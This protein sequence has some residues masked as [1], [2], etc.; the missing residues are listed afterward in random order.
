MHIALV[1]AF[2]CL[3]SSAEVEFIA[4]FR[5][6]AQRTGHR[7]YEVVTSDDIHDCKPDLVITTHE[8]TS[9]L[10]PFFTLGAMW[11]PPAFFEQ[12]PRRI[13]AVLS[14]DGYLVG[15]PSVHRFL[16][17]LEFSTGVRKPRSD[18]RFLPTAAETE[19]APRDAGAPFEL[20]YVGVRW[21]KARHDGLLKQLNE[22]RLI[23]IYG[24]GDAWEGFE[25]TYRGALPFDGAS[26]S[27]ALRRHGIALCIHKVEHRLADIPSMRLF[28]AAAAGALIVAD[29]LPFAR[30]T[31]GDSAFYIDLR[32][33]DDANL[34]RIEEIIAWANAHP[35]AATAMAERSHAILRDQFGIEALVRKTC[36]FAQSSKQEMAERRLQAVSRLAAA[37]EPT[38]PPA[39]EPYLALP[40]TI[41][42]MV[43]V[44]IRTGGR[45]LASLRRAVRSVREQS[46]GRYRILLVDYRARADLARFIEEERTAALEIRYLSCADT[47]FRST[48]LWT[49]LQAV[50]APFF[51]MLDDDDSL[52]PDHFPSLLTAAEAAPQKGFFYTGVL[53]VEDDAE[54]FIWAPNFNGALQ[55]DVAERRELK[56][57]DRFDLAR[58]VGFDN[59]IQSNTWIARSSLLDTETL[60]DPD[61]IVSEDMYLYFMLLRKTDFQLVPCATAYWHWRS[62]QRDNSMLHVTQDI[63]AREGRRLLLRLHQLVL[64]NGLTFA[65]MRRLIDRSPPGEA[66]P[67][68]PQSSARVPLGTQ[69]YLGRDVVAFARQRGLNG[70][71]AEGVWTA[72]RDATLQVSLS[73]PV[74]TVRVGLRLLVA[75]NRAGRR[76]VVELLVNGLPVFAG[77]L[78]GWTS[79]D[80][81]QDLVFRQPTKLLNIT[82]RCRY[83]IC[84]R[85]EGIGADDRQIGVFLSMLT[86][87]RLVGPPNLEPVREMLT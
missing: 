36:D 79:T 26:L 60:A 17:D 73:E 52:M 6:A 47:G 18:F 84:P 49:G 11:S 21:D 55:V 78:D 81:E 74:E 57:L 53:R 62:S 2:P 61:L 13:K 38:Q 35:R 71:E 51:A 70:P 23:N 43:D 3:P 25:Q 67:I 76:Q 40:A 48:A 85:E 1:N 54:D 64:H 50:T 12:D 32:D 83:T 45:D 9:K 37:T 20:C 8:F 42:P 68:W 80:L 33:G 14:Y 56:F 63:W 58:F 46:A 34:R 87:T 29:E 7:A 15:A 66:E 86:C 41:A 27:G 59:F 44:V 19:F 77:P 72:D 22:K 82:V 30:E 16:N 24:P 65:T 10:T 39:A 28:E 31:L 75:M 4:R 69:T 5:L